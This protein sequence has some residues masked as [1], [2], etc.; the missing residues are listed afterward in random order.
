MTAIWREKKERI[1]GVRRGRKV[2]ECM[3]KRRLRL[4]F[5][6]GPDIIRKVDEDIFEVG[7]DEILKQ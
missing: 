3:F 4:I 5:H 2:M 1:A 6:E 7:K